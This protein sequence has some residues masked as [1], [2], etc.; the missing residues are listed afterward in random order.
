M[1]IK[2]IDVNTIAKLCFVAVQSQREAMGETE[3]Y[4]AWEELTPDQQ[5]K[6]I[7]YVV[8]VLTGR[9][10]PDTADG[11]MISRLCAQFADPKKTLKYA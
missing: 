5:G 7:D 1:S 6:T 4:A 2:S 8:G 11:K 9:P 3:E 10:A